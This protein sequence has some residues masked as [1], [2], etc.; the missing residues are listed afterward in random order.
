MNRRDLLRGAAAVAASAAVLK[1]A[2]GEA[3]EADAARPPAQRHP[4]DGRYRPVITPNG[5]AL[6]WRRL[7]DTKVFHLVAE[8]VR[9]EFTDGLVANCWGYNGST[10]GPTIEAVEGDQVRIYVTNRLREP[11][12]VHW[13]GVILESG[14]DG[15][16]GLSQRPIPVG[17][18]YR[19]E[20]TLRYPGTF[21]YHP[22]WDEMTQ[23]AMGMMGMFIVHPRRPEPNPPDRDFAIMLSEWAIP[24]GASTPNP[25][26]MTDFNVLTMNSKSFP[27]T[28]PLVARQGDRVRIRFGNLSGMDNHPIHLHGYSFEIIGSDGGMYPRSARQPHTT[29]IVPTGSCRVIEFIAENPGD[30][31]MHCHMTHHVMN[32]MGHDSPNMTGANVR[33]IDRRVRSMFPGYMSMGQD[34]MAA[35]GEMDMP[36]PDNS[37]PMR[38]GPGAFGNID[39]GGMFTLLKV[40]PNLTSYEDP[41]WFQNP[42]G[43]VARTA[44]AAELSAD[45]IEL[46]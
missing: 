18:T 10:P 23:Q 40:R 6:P 3:Q 9:H 8:E 15:V 20:F 33:G 12:T 22:H 46:G 38:G 41:G 34:G 27:G 25:L 4:Q 30:W 21:M 29:V 39:M 7:G 37:I 11:T 28:A 43:T 31:A 42:A 16:G 32:Q 19:Y 14:M 13:H 17:E 24:I 44:T 45:G 5:S 2:R 1:G 35:M 36:V 26:E